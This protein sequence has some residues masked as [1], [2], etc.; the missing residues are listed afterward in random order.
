MAATGPFRALSLDLWFTTMYY[1]PGLDDRWEEARL[2]VLAGR[3]TRPEGPIGRD[4]LTAALGATRRRL[5]ASGRE[6]VATDPAQL[7]ATTAEALG[8][9]VRGSLDEAA[10]ELSAAGLRESPPTINPEAVR[11]VRGL[12]ARGIPSVLVTNSARRASTWSAF[13]AGAEHP[14]FRRIVSSAD[15]GRHKPDPAMFAEAA[16]LLD[17]PLPAVLHVGDRWELD[18]AG[19]LAAGCG[20]ALYRGLWPRYPPD[21]LPPDGGPA[22]EVAGVWVIDRLEELLTPE[23][24]VR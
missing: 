8:A 10:E 18:V 6:P 20:A 12:D 4:E 13:L 22:S 9:S 5:I 17:V 7:L 24:W 15:L 1:D 3:L 11:L 23:L 14:P 19:A 21:Y 2:A 16:R